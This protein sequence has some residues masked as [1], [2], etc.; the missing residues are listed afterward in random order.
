MNLFKR[1]EKTTEG[2]A[3]E[4]LLKAGG[5]DFLREAAAIGQLMLRLPTQLDRIVTQAEKGKLTVQS[6]LSSDTRK[7]MDRLAQAVNRLSWTVISA[8]LLISGVNLHTGG[9]SFGG[10]LIVLAVSAFL[11][12]M[13]K[14]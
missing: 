10:L 5:E 13:R 12:G 11:W 4:E 6:A 2:Y 8:G 3:T 9:K 14:K 1:T 7:A